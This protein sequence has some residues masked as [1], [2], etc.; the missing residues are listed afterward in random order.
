MKKT[1]NTQRKIFDIIFTVP[2]LELL[3]LFLFSSYGLCVRIELMNSDICILQLFGRASVKA[4]GPDSSN[5]NGLQKK[6][7]HL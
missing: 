1:K 2:Y 5:E 3:I 6:D 4:A 7:A